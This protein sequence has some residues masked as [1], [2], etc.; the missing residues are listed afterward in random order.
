MNKKAYDKEIKAV[1]KQVIRN[2]QVVPPAISYTIKDH[3]CEGY[4]SKYIDVDC[5]NRYKKDLEK[6]LVS[7]LKGIIRE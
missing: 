5:F 2:P 1:V 6:V 3:G 4:T 7:R